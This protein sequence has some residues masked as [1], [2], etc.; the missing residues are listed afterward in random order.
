LACDHYKVRQGSH[1]QF[2]TG[3]HQQSGTLRQPEHSG[4]SK[5]NRSRS[6]NN[7]VA[8]IS[9]EVDVAKETQLPPVTSG[10]KPFQKNKSTS[11]RP[12]SLDCACNFAF[13][14]LCSGTVTKDGK[15]YILSN[16]GIKKMPDLVAHIQTTFQSKL[17]IL[18][19]KKETSHPL[20]LKGFIN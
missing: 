2:K 4:T 5:K 12:A 15:W 11:V 20:S 10:R 6:A 17:L 18:P 19:L 3:K 14:V 9:S 8:N 16:K 1:I 7:V 13:K